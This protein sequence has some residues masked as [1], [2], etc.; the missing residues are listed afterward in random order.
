[1]IKL[2]V[3]GCAYKGRTTFVKK[4]IKKTS[5]TSLASNLLF[6]IDQWMYSPSSTVSPVTFEVWDFS[7][8]VCTH[9]KQ[10]NVIDIHIEILL[11]KSSLLLFK[12][13]YLPCGV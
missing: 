11:W 2:L 1:M 12:T 10:S 8:K 7:G 9:M 3:V 6:E 13:S 5:K 4:L